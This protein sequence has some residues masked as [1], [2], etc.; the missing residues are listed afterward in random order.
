[1]IVNKKCYKDDLCRS[2]HFETDFK[3]IQIYSIGFD[4]YLRFMLQ[5]TLKFLLYPFDN[6]EYILKF[7]YLHMHFGAKF[8]RKAPRIRK[9]TV[10]V[11]PLFFLEKQ[12]NPFESVDDLFV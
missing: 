8:V 5:K 1:M 10:F 6:T 11:P 2:N 7:W 12:M 3:L 9:F 4:W